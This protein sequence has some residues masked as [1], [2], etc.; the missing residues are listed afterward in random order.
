MK[1]E[2]HNIYSFQAMNCI[3]EGAQ[4]YV[5]DKKEKKLYHLNNEKVTKVLA[6]IKDADDNS[7]RYIF[8]KENEGESK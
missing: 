1:E 2:F 5:L 4:V 7:S 6:I 8:W 3:E